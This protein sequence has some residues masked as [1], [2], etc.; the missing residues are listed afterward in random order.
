[1]STTLHRPMM[2]RDR[3]FRQE[4]F[5]HAW[6]YLRQARPLLLSVAA[7]PI[8]LLMLLLL[9]ATAAQP[10]WLSSFRGS[11]YAFLAVAAG[12][13]FALAFGAVSFAG[14]CELG[15]D[16]LLRSLPIR[17]GPLVAGVFAAGALGAAAA[18]GIAMVLLAGLDILWGR[19]SLFTLPWP[20]E[21]LMGAVYWLGLGAAFLAW[22]IFFS[23]KMRRVI[24]AL[25]LGAAVAY[26]CDT[27]LTAWLTPN[28]RFTWERAAELS[29]YRLALVALVLFVDAG[30]IRG[31]LRPEPVSRGS[32]ALALLRRAVEAFAAVCPT[33]AAAARRGFL[34]G[35]Q[36]DLHRPADEQLLWLQTR[37]AG[38]LVPVM[39]TVA[40]VFLAVVTGFGTVAYV[41][42]PPHAARSFW[43]FVMPLGVCVILG[44]L[45]VTGVFVFGPDR[46][47]GTRQFLAVRPISPG[48]IWLARQRWGVRWCL[49]WSI[50]LA[51]W[52]CL[53]AVT[54][55]TNLN[56]DGT[57]GATLFYSLL[58]GAVLYAA[59]QLAGM[60]APGILHALILAAGLTLAVAMPVMFF[61]VGPDEIIPGGSFAIT[62]AILLAAFFW[63]SRRSLRSWLE[64]RA[65]GG[66]RDRLSSP[67]L[68]GLVVTFLILPWTRVMF[69][70]RT[71]VE[72]LRNM[73]AAAQVRLQQWMEPQ[74][75]SLQ[76]FAA[77]MEVARRVKFS[78]PLSSL[79]V[80]RRTWSYELGEDP[81]QRFLESESAV[82]FFRLLAE[83]SKQPYADP[84][85]DALRRG[86]PWERLDVNS[87]AG[88]LGLELQMITIPALENLARAA[89]R[90]GKIQ[91]SRSLLIAALALRFRAERTYP[92]AFGD[93]FASGRDR[94]YW[95]RW[96]DA[97]WEW[98]R[99][100]GQ[101]PQSLRE[102]LQDIQD[103]V[104]RERVP[105][106]VRTLLL[107]TYW[108]GPFLRDAPIGMGREGPRFAWWS[109]E[110]WFLPIAVSWVPGEWQLHQARLDRI[111]AE[112]LPRAVEYDERGVF[113]WQ[114]R[115]RLES[116]KPVSLWRGVGWNAAA[117]IRRSLEDAFFSR[118]LGDLHVQA[119]CLRLALRMYKL[120]HGRY[121]GRLEELVPRYLP[122]IPRVP[123]SG[124]DFLLSYPRRIRKRA[125]RRRTRFWMPGFMSGVPAV[126]SSCWS[127]TRQKTVMGKNVSSEI[128]AGRTRQNYLTTFWLGLR[129]RRTPAGRDSALR[130]A[131]PGPSA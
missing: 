48:R 105:L 98:S 97:A 44:M 31:W 5:A 94:A 122:R 58:G 69:L 91:E 87:Q 43:G 35:F 99:S 108:R 59:G 113:P 129:R 84:L 12:G 120:E 52:I 79:A 15:T 10:E 47:H 33:L 77:T 55:D 80:G 49:V 125:R 50:L 117:S 107:G 61:P 93:F 24:W 1:M 45:A 126:T 63:Q 39:R 34:S 20:Y 103:V 17:P 104:V 62:V 51:A 7:G 124:E 100:E 29:H 30:L 119:T 95:S 114:F 22:G 60:F 89:V 112:Y 40:A 14:E 110:L 127:W 115:R 27:S 37:Q 123:G 92:C 75:E 96:A 38:A 6:R 46:W 116:S 9:A 32:A 3:G 57:L 102:M 19:A 76:G 28:Y 18:G 130:R 86:S 78:G 74:P 2:G 13:L 68:W 4:A 70:P 85:V 71:D 26:L 65:A 36:P 21:D 8:L 82:D 64:E 131:H 88:T 81:G 118:A 11:A 67:I 54:S 109:D 42:L 41:T 53:S 106:E 73:E 128:T 121:P 66:F 23:L 16:A 111:L 83:L 56:R 25:I 72:S 101:T 90:A